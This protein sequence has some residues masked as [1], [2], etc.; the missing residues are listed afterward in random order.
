MKTSQLSIRGYVQG[1][2]FRH[3]TTLL[4]KQQKLAGKVRNKN[5]GSVEI[6]IQATDKQLAHFIEVLKQGDTNP[7][8]SVDDV[9]IISQFD[10]P[11]INGFETIY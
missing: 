11:E 9:Q 5:D 3:S 4:A 2:G 1:V 10:E 7:F 6:F 8:A